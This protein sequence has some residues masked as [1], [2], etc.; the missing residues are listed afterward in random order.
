MA[1]IW[2][3][4]LGV[5]QVGRHDN[6]FELGG[7]SLA[8]LHLVRAAASL[9][10]RRLL[11]KDVFATPTLAD[12]AGRAAN[13]QTALPLLNAARKETRTLFVLHDGW[14]STLDYTALALALEPGGCSVIGVPYAPDDMEA[15]ADLTQLAQRH[16]AA[17]TASGRSGPFLLA[18]WSLGGAL[19]PL[20]AQVLERGGHRV[21][22]VGALDPF[23]PPAP[24][25]EAAIRFDDE[26]LEFLGIL[27]PHGQHGRLQDERVLQGLLARAGDEPDGLVRLLDALLER[28]S[29]QDLHEYGAL[30]AQELARMFVGARRLRAAGNRPHAPVEL[31][32]RVTAWWSRDRLSKEKQAF[33]AWVKCRLPMAQNVVAA[34]H[35]QL[36]RSPMLF[37]QL[38][39]E[40]LP[41]E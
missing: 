31:A 20:V 11:L 36:V 1:R 2:S 23:I 16:A 25:C 7:H 29:S 41:R 14:G 24:G 19:A 6:F 26:L 33:S 35:L 13:A 30:G 5:A 38:H 15:P 27:L 37:D 3:E 9:P 12:L 22:F 18:G 32:A 21:D 40:L 17:I 8:A 10:G 34:D 4:V 28:V 39:R